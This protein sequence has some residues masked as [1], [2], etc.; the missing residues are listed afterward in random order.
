MSNFTKH[1]KMN[2]LP[3]LL[4]YVTHGFT[5][6]LK[7]WQGLIQ[8]LHSLKFIHNVPLLLTTLQCEHTSLLYDSDAHI[9]DLLH[10]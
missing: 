9:E 6:N 1:K 3:L 7:S 10:L 8:Y 4:E 2:C 5:I